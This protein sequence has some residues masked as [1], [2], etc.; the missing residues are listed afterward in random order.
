[1]VGAATARTNIGLEV[2]TAPNNDLNVAGKMKRKAAMPQVM[3]KVR[4]KKGVKR[5]FGFPDLAA[6]IPE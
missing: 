4:R 3:P 6:S 5:P 2:D 1:M